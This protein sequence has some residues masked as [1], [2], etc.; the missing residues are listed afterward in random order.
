MWFLFFEHKKRKNIHIFCIYRNTVICKY[1]NTED[2]RA[3][4]LTIQ[5]FGNCLSCK[6]AEQNREMSLTH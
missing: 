6:Q 1:R 5:T 4:T 3:K 2:K